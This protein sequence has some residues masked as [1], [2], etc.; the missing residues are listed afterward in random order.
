MD[1]IRPLDPKDAIA[2]ATLRLASTKAN[3]E[4]FCTSLSE[5]Q[6]A[7]VDLF[8]Q[9]I[10]QRHQLENNRILGYFHHG[11][12]LGAIGVEQLYGD[13]RRHKGRIWGLMVS[14]EHRRQGIA[15]ELCNAAVETAKDY[16]VEKL[17]LELT[18][19]AVA[20]MKLYRSL[21][22]RIETVE[23]MALKFEGRYLDEIR[24]A[25]CF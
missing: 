15:R 2:L 1:K 13:L 12:M 9:E 16:G 5:L 24:M 20:A 19:E 3:P 11:E 17:S 14:P 10:K 25:I 22:F 6:T 21:D 18:S 8:A 23:P 4:C 7:T